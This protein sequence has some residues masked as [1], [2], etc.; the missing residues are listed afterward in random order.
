MERLFVRLVNGALLLSIAGAWTW[1]VRWAISVQRLAWHDGEPVFDV[2]GWT[3]MEL[4]EW[5][6]I[7]AAA[8]ATVAFGMYLVYYTVLPQKFIDLQKEAPT[9]ATVEASEQDSRI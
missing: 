8:M 4:P 1:F 6:W 9:G 7:G 2:A 3:T 5:L